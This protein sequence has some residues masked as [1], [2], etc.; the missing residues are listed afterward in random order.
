MLQ[1]RRMRDTV[2]DH[3]Q[4]FVKPALASTYA[5]SHCRPRASGQTWSLREV[6]GPGRRGT[7][8]VLDRS[9]GVLA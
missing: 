8:G 4:C 5:C 3:T 1:M 2:S 7:P 9:R 6:P